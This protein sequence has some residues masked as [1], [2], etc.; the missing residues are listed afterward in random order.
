MALKFL[1]DEC[2]SPVLVHLA[3]ERGYEAYHIAHRGL[4]GREDQ[5]LLP[6]LL[7]EELVLVTNN[8]RDFEALLGDEGAVHPGLVVLVTQ[9]RPSVQVALFRAVLD[10][11]RGRT[12]LIN[13]VVEVDLDEASKALLSAN[14]KLSEATWNAI[15]KG[16]KPA[17]VDRDL[18]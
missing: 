7:K 14:E 5:A 17:V 9:V 11:L 1:I 13:R 16:V 2:A 6:V 18:P 4:A 12:D 15:E 3:H 10:H 8:G